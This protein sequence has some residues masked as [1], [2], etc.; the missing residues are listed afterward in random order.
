V[1]SEKGAC[2]EREKER[3]R[4]QVLSDRRTIRG[5]TGQAGI[6]SPRARCERQRMQQF[7]LRDAWPN[8]SWA[9]HVLSYHLPPTYLPTCWPRAKSC[10]DTRPSTYTDTLPCH[11]GA[12]PSAVTAQHADSHVGTLPTARWPRRYVM[13]CP[14]HGIWCRGG[15]NKRPSASPPPCV[16]QPWRHGRLVRYPVSC[17]LPLSRN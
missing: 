6:D 13:P 14:S 4:A 17:A 12:L 5:R 11:D 1:S 10:A 2:V 16:R 8:T 7:V 15:G 3:V 9:R